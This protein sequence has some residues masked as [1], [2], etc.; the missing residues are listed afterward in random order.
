VDERLTHTSLCPGIE[1]PE[2]LRSYL[3]DVWRAD[4]SLTPNDWSASNP[5]V[6]QCA[7]TALIVQDYFG[8]ELLRGCTE[9][10]T[11]YW[12]RLPNGQEIDLTAEQFDAEPAISGVELRSREYVLSYPATNARYQRLLANLG[13]RSTVCSAGSTS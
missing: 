2:D 1:T 8:G 9:G 11:H 7:V 5:A 13:L 6:G 10:G 3:R 4:T 12:N